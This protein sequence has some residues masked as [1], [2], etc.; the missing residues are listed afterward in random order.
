MSDSRTVASR[1]ARGEVCDDARSPQLGS[2]STSPSESDDSFVTVEDPKEQGGIHNDSDRDHTRQA[3]SP[4]KGP[5]YPNVPTRGLHSTSSSTATPTCDAPSESAI[6]PLPGQ[7]TK[8][9]DSARSAQRY[10]ASPHRPNGPYFSP[11]LSTNTSEPRSPASRR[12][13]PASRSSHGIETTSGPP[14]ALSTQR[15]HNADSSWKN[16]QRKDSAD[17]SSI[18]VR[19][20]SVGNIACGWKDVAQR[21]DRRRSGSVNTP[22]RHGASTSRAAERNM[23]HSVFLRQSS[24][25]DD[26]DDDATLRINGRKA[27]ATTDGAPLQAAR[28]DLFLD[29]AR[30]NSPGTDGSDIMSRSERRR[31]SLR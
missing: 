22:P 27:M 15:S 10:S 5:Q 17:P 26:G 20:E 29:L 24:I 3:R 16:A 2:S 13:P 12:R 8:I 19:P 4:S 1:G 30:S 14:P 25:V 11:P 6:T 31:V 28:Q 23:M 21:Q 7:H 9:S 18:R